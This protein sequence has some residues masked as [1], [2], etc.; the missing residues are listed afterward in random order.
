MM[1]D[2]SPPP[3]HPHVDGKKYKQHQKSNRAGG[4]TSPRSPLLGEGTSIQYFFHS[5]HFEQ[6]CYVLAIKPS[7]ERDDGR[8]HLC[9]GVPGACHAVVFRVTSLSFIIVVS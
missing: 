6:S 8:F 3:P 4:T 1:H 9:A 2:V 7:P 5:F